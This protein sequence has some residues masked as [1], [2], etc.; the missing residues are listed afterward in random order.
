MNIECIRQWLHFKPKNR[1]SE[2]G[3]EGEFDAS[4]HLV[5]VMLSA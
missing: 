1:V 4:A 3:V 5:E 2:P